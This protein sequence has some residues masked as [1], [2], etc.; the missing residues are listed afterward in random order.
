MP[1]LHKLT[2]GRL[3]DQGHAVALVTDGRMSGASGKVPAAIHVT[4]EAAENGPLALLRDG[5]MISL[6]ANAGRLDV[7]VSA[8]ELAR[9]TPATA[10]DTDVVTVGRGLFEAARR[11][12]SQAEQGASFLFAPG[13]ES[14]DAVVALAATQNA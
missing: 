13:T 11:G 2:P 12:V 5:D 9:R 10:S 4:P 8:A 7:Q 6:D 3:Q 14:E 1:E